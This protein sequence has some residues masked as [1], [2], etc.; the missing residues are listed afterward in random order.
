MF[1]RC[2]SKGYRYP[3]ENKRRFAPSIFVHVF[4]GCLSL[5][6]GRCLGRVTLSC[7]GMSTPG[8]VFKFAALFFTAVAPIISQRVCRALLAAEESEYVL[9]SRSGL[10]L[11]LCVPAICELK[12]CL[13]ARETNFN[14]RNW[15]L[16]REPLLPAGIHAHT[17]TV[18]ELL[19]SSLRRQ[20][21]PC[22]ECNAGL[23]DE[24]NWKV[25]SERGWCILLR[26]VGRRA[27]NK[28]HERNGGGTA[29]ASV[30]P[31][32]NPCQGTAK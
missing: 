28:R 25:E 24:R 29:S 6:A 13:S 9:S 17:A 32:P 1:L 10:S 5:W 30:Q 19:L 23:G 12:Y 15:S 16:S 8:F 7:R 21:L 31:R 11:L 2:K 18:V 20:W 27:R 4:L 22:N 3:L 14:S 26:S